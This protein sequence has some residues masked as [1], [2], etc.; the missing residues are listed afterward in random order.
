MT[1]RSLVLVLSTLLFLPAIAFSQNS[2]QELN[3]QF[4]EAVRK[5]DSAN[6]TALLDKGADVN[7]KF[8]YGMTA[9][10]KA[11]ERGHVEV[12]KI[13][14]AR[15]VD[16]TVKDTFYGQ[17]AMSWAIQNDHAEVVN[18]ILDK[19]PSSANEV[20]MAGVSNAKPPFVQI[21]LDKGTVSKE[22][23]TRGLAIT[24]LDK[25]YAPIAEMLKKA[26]AIP[27]PEVKAE[28]LQSYAGTYK[29]PNNPDIT[30]R[31]GDG[32]MVGNLGAQR[33]QPLYAID[34][35]TFSPMFVDGVSVKFKVD[36]GKV[37]G[38]LFTDGKNSTE[39]AR[40]N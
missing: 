15:G 8:R 7:A 18:A 26:G 16:V 38:L 17:T 21:A 30:I 23:M 39:Y 33:P 27:P 28:T 4:W 10:F 31:F 25:D 19:Q 36:G 3:D 37:S 14:L 6:V 40:A 22:A 12:V 32:V 29:A 11:A 5:G 34:Q 35:V 13:L 2:K 1:S 9:L 24:T 20:F